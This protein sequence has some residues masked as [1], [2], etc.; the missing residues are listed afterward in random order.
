MLYR[1]KQASLSLPERDSQTL[2]VFPSISLSAALLLGVPR[3]VMVQRPRSYAQAS[4]MAFSK[5]SS[6]EDLQPSHPTSGWLQR[7]I[8]APLPVCLQ[9]QY[10]LCI[11]SLHSDAESLIHQSREKTASLV[12]ES[13]LELTKIFMTTTNNINKEFCAELIKPTFLYL[14]SHRSCVSISAHNCEYANN[15]YHSQCHF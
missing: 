12:K 11:L 6:A 5:S 4:A 14:Q 8:T 15:S 3:S 1:W 2:Q 10:L 9:M 13:F 7:A